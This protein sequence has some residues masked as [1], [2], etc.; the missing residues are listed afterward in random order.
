VGMFLPEKISKSVCSSTDFHILMACFA[1]CR[2]FLLCNWKF[3][4]HE[5][6][7]QFK[8][9]KSTES[10]WRIERVITIP[11]TVEEKSMKGMCL[12]NGYQTNHI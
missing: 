3:L 9:R 2:W 6:I 4:L 7:I 5:A 8:A 1:M 12:L 11:S 10:C